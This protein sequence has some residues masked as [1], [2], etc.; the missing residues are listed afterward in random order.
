MNGDKSHMRLLLVFKRYSRSKA[1]GTNLRIDL[2]QKQARSSLDKMDAYDTAVKRQ[3]SI[4]FDETDSE[5]IESKI[6]FVRKIDMD[7]QEES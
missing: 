3:E 1:I 2:M 5:K 4:L 7:T 6:S